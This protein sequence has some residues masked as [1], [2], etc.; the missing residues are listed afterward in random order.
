MPS[1]RNPLELIALALVLALPAQAQV[2]PEETDPVKIMTAVQNRTEGDKVRA[3]MVMTIGDQA[4]RE[5]TRALQSR[6]MLFP[7]GKR[8]ILVFD[9]PVDVKGTGFLSMDYDDGDRDDDQWLWLPSL[10]KTTRISAGEKSGSFMGT[11]FSYADMTEQDPKHWEYTLLQASVP[12]DGEDCWLIEAKPKTKKAEDETGYLKT[13]TLVSKA[14]ML[15]LKVKAWVKK[16]K[17]IKL[18]AFE[19]IK[20]VDGIWVA[21]TLKAKVMKGDD[22]DLSTVI[23]FTEMSFNNAD[24]TEALFT[25][26]QL[27]K[28]L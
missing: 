21:H 16:G 6:T 7:E 19:D 8:Q 23:K 12:V 10:H 22:L 17:K 13:Q 3:R 1:P 15:P 2:G 24:V 5:R 25:E 18:I 11:A 28:G 9:D 27:A 14:K 20:Q 26:A 4:G